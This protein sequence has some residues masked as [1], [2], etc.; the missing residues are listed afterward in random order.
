MCAII[1]IYTVHVHVWCIVLPLVAQ[2]TLNTCMNK[3]QLHV[4]EHVSPF[5]TLVLCVHV[6]LYSPKTKSYTL[7]LALYKSIESQQ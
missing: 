7:Y 6:D 2:I 1:Y 5:G 4:H 3:V